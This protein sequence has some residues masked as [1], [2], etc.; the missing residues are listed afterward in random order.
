MRWHLNS[1]VFLETEFRYSPSG[2]ARYQWRQPWDLVCECCATGFC[3]DVQPRRVLPAGRELLESLA[4]DERR[5]FLARRQL[6]A[7]PKRLAELLGSTHIF[8]VACKSLG[9]L[10]VAQVF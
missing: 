8:P 6:I 2:K 7:P 9:D 1:C 3:I 4:V 5:Y 10:V